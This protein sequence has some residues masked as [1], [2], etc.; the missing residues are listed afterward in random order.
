MDKLLDEART[1]PVYL[2]QREIV[3]IL[4][5]VIRDNEALARYELHAFAIMPNHV[6]M[7]VTPHVPLAVL[8]KS[9]KGFSAR[10]ANQI[11]MRTGPFWQDESY[12]HVVRNTTEFERIQRYIEQNPVRAGLVNEASEYRWSSAAWATRRS[13]AGLEAR[14]TRPT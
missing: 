2:R 3:D 12:D 13:P 8:T 11:L 10:K 6:H 5:T 7:L 14:P 1:G 4:M 9:L